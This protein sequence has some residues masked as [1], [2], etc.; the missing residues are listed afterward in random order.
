MRISW[1]WIRELVETPLSAADAAD[2]L[3]AGGIEVAGLDVPTKRAG[4]AVR[5]H[6]AD[7][8]VP[9]GLERGDQRAPDQPA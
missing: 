3:I 4:T 1:R 6:H 2:R 7:G 8:G 5:P 9:V